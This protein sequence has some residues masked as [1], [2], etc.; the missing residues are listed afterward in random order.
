LPG[1]TD[2]VFARD[3]QPIIHLLPALPDAWPTGSVKGLRARGA[4]LIDINWQ[5]SKL[6]DAAI[7]SLKGTP[8]AVFH[9]GKAIHSNTTAGHTYYFNG[10]VLN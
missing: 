1:N 7:K 9:E 10:Q 4:F 3:R 2:E 8:L 5:N 6:E